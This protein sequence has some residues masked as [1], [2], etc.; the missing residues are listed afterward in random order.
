MNEMHVAMA[1]MELLKELGGWGLWP[2]LTILFLAP[3]LVG[4]MG[5][6][7][8]VRSVRNLERTMIEGIHQNR[9]IIR[10]IETKYDNNVI[11]V[12]EGQKLIRSYQASL[13]TMLQVVRD[14]TTAL[15]RVTERIAGM[16]QG[17][18]Q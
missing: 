9:D 11:L 18:G 8:G 2:L 10:S 16:R 17:G 15:T 4:L 3:P 14:N 12:Q 7:L 6:F 5:V 13:D 1:I